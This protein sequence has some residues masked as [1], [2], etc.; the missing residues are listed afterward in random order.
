VSFTSLIFFPFLA[1]YLALC[2]V[3]RGRGWLWM[4]ALFS[5]FFYGY[6]DWRF[7]FLLYLSSGMAWFCGVR[8]AQADSERGRKRYVTLSVVSSLAILG[9]FK[10]FNF[11]AASLG[12]MAGAFGLGLQPR[13]AEIIL[14]IGISFYT[15]HALSY[16]IDIYRRK[17]DRPAD[18][19]SVIVYLSFF[20]QLV[21]GPIVRAH[22]F[23][24]QIAR[25]PVFS[26][27]KIQ[28][29]LLIIAW[30]YF[31]K[32]VVADSIALV[33]DPVF[34][35]PQAYSSGQL[36]ASLVAYA[37]QIYCDFAGYSFVA[38]GIAKLIGFDFPA[39]FIAPYFS[40]SFREFWRRWHISLSSFLRDYL[41]FSLGGNRQGRV[42]E[43]LNLM[44]TMFLGG[45]WHGASYN[46]I[47]W[48][49]LHG[50]YL[51]GEHAIS[52]HSARPARS[53]AH[54]LWTA[55]VN[56]ARLLLVFA[57]TCF[58][59]IFFRISSF[60]GAMTYISGIAAL[61]GLTVIQTKFLFLKAFALIGLVVCVDAV[62]VERRRMV[63]LRRRPW[64]V[65]ACVAVL[66]CL[67][68]LLGSFGGGAFIYFQF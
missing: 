37:F 22:S 57:L 2:V 67:V 35:L 51:V 45:L 1:G 10:Y 13:F 56:T 9:L 6:W 39:N 44:V 62:L 32:I 4:T 30:G 48:G 24:P 3:L 63:R 64:A 14:P 43:R 17:L 19:L 59:W 23:L 8:I 34:L 53:P 26:L 20:P 27:R 68:Q 65:A 7:L 29:G 16:T 58:A 61:Q 11:F 25:G 21:A 47:V 40:R 41:Y 5:A 49:V 15:F 60:S 66:A 46:F 31:L 50:A 12:A 38:I 52:R 54:P 55:G 18:L 33:V 36:L 28:T 42:R